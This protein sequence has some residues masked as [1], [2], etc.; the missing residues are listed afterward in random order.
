MKGLLLCP[1][2]GLFEPWDIE[3]CMSTWCQSSL[4]GEKRVVVTAKESR[5]LPSMGGDI[6]RPESRAP[7]SRM[8]SSS[9]LLSSSSKNFCGCVSTV[10]G[11]WR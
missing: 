2:K 3:G 11:D 6:S 1:M 9:M 7:L 10:K 5:R 8:F 4:L